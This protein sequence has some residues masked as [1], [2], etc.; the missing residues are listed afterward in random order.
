[1]SNFQMI[2]AFTAAIA[3]IPATWIPLYIFRATKFN[4]AASEFKKAFFPIKQTLINA[5]SSLQETITAEFPKHEAAM[6]IFADFLKTT[7]RKRYDRINKKWGE[8]KEAC[9]QQLQS[10]DSIYFENMHYLIEQA[11]NPE[12][13]NQLPRLHLEELAQ[14]ETYLISSNQIQKENIRLHIDNL[15]E[16][17]NKY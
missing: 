2:V 5:N 15:L 1:M 12:I 14:M 13:Q 4:S 10:D 3:L 6:L 9:E 8:Y 16:I 17:A 11:K 7:D